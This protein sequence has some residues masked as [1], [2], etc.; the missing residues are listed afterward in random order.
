MKRFIPVLPLLFL[1]NWLTIGV[2][3]QPREDYRLIAGTSFTQAKNVYLL[4]LIEADQLVRK[5]IESDA[6]LAGLGQAK[7]Q[8]LAE[9]L[10]ACGDSAAC[11]AAAM[12]FTSAEIDSVAMRLAELA[13]REAV[14]QQLVENHLMPSG[15][16]QRYVNDDLAEWFAAA[17]RQDARTVNHIIA[18]YAQGKKSCLETGKN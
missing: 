12:P 9:S 4:T 15:A 16:Y 13:R 10:T 1:A 17:W 2:Q 5:V 8:R 11:Y 3:G 18:V 14:L 7:R 6:V